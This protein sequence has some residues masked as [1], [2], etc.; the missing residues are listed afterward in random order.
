MDEFYRLFNYMALL[1]LVIQVNPWAP[2][3]IIGTAVFLIFIKYNR[4]R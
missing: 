1:F 2:V 3:A 4:G